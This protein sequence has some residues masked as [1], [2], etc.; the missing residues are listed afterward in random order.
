VEGNLQFASVFFLDVQ[1]R[2]SG[3]YD[4]AVIQGHLYDSMTDS[5]FAGGVVAQFANAFHLFCS[6]EGLGV[7]DNEEQIT[8]LFIEQTHQH[9]QGN[10]LHYYRFIPDASPEKFAMIGAMS[11]VPQQL[12]ESI[13]RTAMA[14]T[15]RQYHRPEIAVYMFGNLFFD[16]LEKTL[17][18][19]GN[20]A[21]CNHMAF[22]SISVC[23]YNSYRPSRPFLFNSFGNH[24]FDNRSV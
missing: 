1:Q 22:L 9:I 24:N 2:T 7:I 21:D 6:L 12:D 20:F 14:D 13:N 16:R 4:A 10:L 15:Y 11:T 17:Q 18:F 8:V 3:D 23:Q 5:V 19:F